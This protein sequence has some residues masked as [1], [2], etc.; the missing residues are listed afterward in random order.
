MKKPS[1]EK[2]VWHALAG[3][4][5]LGIFV[6]SSL[7]G[8]GEKYYDLRIFVERK[9]A[10][11]AEFFILTYLLWKA[12]FFWHL[13]RQKRLWFAALFSLLWAISDEFHQLFVF[14][15]EGKISDI[16]IDLAGILLFCAAVTAAEKYSR[17]KK[18]PR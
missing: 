6:L 13:P 7:E 1:R 8:S 9:G 11:V 17:N 10:H 15:R 12:L 3:L 14:G 18:N 5:L 2:I 16:G 4:W